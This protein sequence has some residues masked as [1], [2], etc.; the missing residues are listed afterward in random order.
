VVHRNPVCGDF[1]V[2]VAVAD[3]GLL[4]LDAE[5]LVTAVF[6]VMLHRPVDEAAPLAARRHPVNALDG[7]FRQHDIDAFAHGNES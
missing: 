1:P 5:S 4:Q 2:Q 7:R 3:G 6:H